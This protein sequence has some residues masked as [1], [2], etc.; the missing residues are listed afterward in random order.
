MNGARP[1]FMIQS[2][3][4]PH[5]RRCSCLDPANHPKPS[6][7]IS[8]ISSRPPHALSFLICST[9]EH[10]RPHRPRL[11]IRVHTGLQLSKRVPGATRGAFGPCHTCLWWRMAPAQMRQPT[12]S[13]AARPVQS[14]APDAVVDASLAPV[15]RAKLEDPATPDGG[16][17]SVSGALP[18]AALTNVFDKIEAT[19]SRLEIVALI[20]ALFKTTAQHHPDDL[21]KVVYLSINRVSECL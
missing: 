10:P 5:S 3:F 18:Y 9:R 21:L 11:K 16:P 8:L 4:L 20:S 7:F 13:F 1:W 6:S 12:L 19:S 14:R 17:P 15:K 2:A